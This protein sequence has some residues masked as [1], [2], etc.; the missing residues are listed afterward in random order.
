MEEFANEMYVEHVG[1]SVLDGRLVSAQIKVDDE[2][3]S[4]RNGGPP[5]AGD[6]GSRLF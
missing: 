2:A 4:M 1:V 6:H 5:P 3:P